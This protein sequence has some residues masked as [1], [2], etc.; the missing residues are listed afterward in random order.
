MRWNCPHCET[1]INLKI[2]L[3]ETPRVYAKCSA[4]AGI[5]LLTLKT[6]AAPIQNILPTPPIV[7]SPPV[8]PLVTV[9]P[10]VE[11]IT[12]PPFRIQKVYAT[13]PAFLLDARTMV[14]VPAHF[15]TVEDEAKENEPEFDLT[16]SLRAIQLPKISTRRAPL[17]VAIAIALTSGTYLAI[18]VKK[19]LK[20]STSPRVAS[21]E[22]SHKR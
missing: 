3:E 16:A 19:I 21:V 2:N 18:Q 12:P 20:E 11:E 9:T 6:A 17:L 7:L 22:K 15:S 10:A 14:D 5:S 1:G 8:T 13:P 4:C